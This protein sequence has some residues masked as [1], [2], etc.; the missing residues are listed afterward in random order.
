MTDIFKTWQDL[1]N[2]LDAEIDIDVDDFLIKQGHDKSKLSESV[3]DISKELLQHTFHPELLPENT[4]LSKYK[5]IKQINSGGQGEIYLAE[6]SDGIYKKTV[7]IKFVAQRYSFETLKQQFLQEMQ[8]LADLNHPGIV[9]ILDGG[10]TN[11]DQPWL[12]LEYIDGLHIDEYCLKE[13]LSHEQIVKLFINLCEALN[14]MHQRGVV[15]MDIKAS[16]ILINTINNIPYP[17][18]ID[19]GI[20]NIENNENN[21]EIENEDIF[22]TAGFSAPE[23]LA[24]DKTDNRADIYSLCMLLAQLLTKNKVF[25]IGLESSLDRLEMLNKHQVSKDLIQIIKK[26]T[27]KKPADRYLNVDDLSLDLNN[28][29]H[30]LPLIDNQNNL[31][32]ILLKSLKR[33]KFGVLVALLMLTTAFGFAIK[34]TTDIAQL[35]QMTAKE[36]NASDELFNFMLTDLFT[37]LSQIG[38]TD[39]LKLVTEKSLEHL[40]K[41]SSMT[42]DAKTHLQR[43]KAYTNAGKVYDSLELSEQAVKSYDEGL[44]SLGFI[45]SNND[46]KKS[47]LS[48][49]SLIKNLKGLT[50]TAEGQQ[51]LTEENLL[52]SLNISNKLLKLYPKEDLHN[53]YETHTQLGWY[54]MEYNAPE[55]ALTHINLAINTAK[56]MNTRK[57]DFK[58]LFNLSQAYQVMAWYQFDYGDSD[59]AVPLL[60]LATDLAN[61]TV[62]ED[63]NSIRFFFNQTTLYNQLSYFYLETCEINKAK[64]IID[65][66]ILIGEKL[67]QKAPKNL[68]YQRELAYSYTTAGQLAEKQND[69][70]LSL[71]FY[72]KSLKFTQLMYQMDSENFSTANDYAYDLIHLGSIHEKL[73]QS[74][75]AQ[76]MWAKAIDIMKPVHILEPNNKYYTNTLISALLKVG[77]YQ[78]AQPLITEL[79]KTGFNDS[80]FENLLKQHNLN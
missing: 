36:K 22:G 61:R 49:L 68:D 16:N 31:G 27:N 9:Q 62:N 46:Y 78:Q 20:S 30:Q 69:L 44:K 43:A 32:H 34:Y 79:K 76:I 40:N 59:K 21:I 45:A 67:Q 1:N 58:W 14:F 18:I 65:Q 4:L 10:L 66:A 35:Q 64:Q 71:N 42:L 12:V 25:N 41:Q 73:L 7:V 3:I 24:K 8:L 19:F 28:Y 38:R 15:H 60:I 51:Q 74:N 70:P 48:Q 33:H 63:G 57:L 6:R 54:Y 77:D 53:K 17:V 52:E 37:N 13:N 11:Q 5:I 80:D 23:Q 39:I 29:L 26:S 72:N 50:L 55:K 47:Y 2:K 56:E 75:Q